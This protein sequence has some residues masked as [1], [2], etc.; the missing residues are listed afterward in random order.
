MHWDKI[1]TS[2]KTFE[3]PKLVLFVQFKVS[4][5]AIDCTV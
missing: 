3:L 4:F 2:Y 1:S 5:S